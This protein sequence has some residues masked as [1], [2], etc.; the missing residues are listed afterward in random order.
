MDHQHSE[1]NNVTR[2]LVPIEDSQEQL[3]G[4]ARS[5]LYGLVNAGHLTKVNIG[6]RG[7]ITADSI[8]AYVE[9]LTQ[10]AS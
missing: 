2:K 9:S 7:F 5:T 8:D 4:I 10:E 6:R 1:G 3:G